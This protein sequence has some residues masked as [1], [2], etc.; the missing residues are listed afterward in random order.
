[1]LRLHSLG[2]PAPREGPES[3]HG[4]T[5]DGR[6]GIPPAPLDAGLRG[7]RPRPVSQGPAKNRGRELCESAAF[8]AVR[9]ESGLI[10]LPAGEA[11]AQPLVGLIGGLAVLHDQANQVLASLPV[12]R[13]VAQIVAGTPQLTGIAAYQCQVGVFSG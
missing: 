9:W 1:M 3:T 2:R 5:G 6:Q 13:L 8:F 10:S 4:R 11:G 12:E 7:A